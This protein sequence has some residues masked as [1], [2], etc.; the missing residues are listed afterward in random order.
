MQEEFDI[1]VIGSGLGGLECGVMLSREG[2]GVCIVEQAAVPGGCLQSFR[3]RGHSI[4]TGMHYVGSMQQGGIMRRYFDYF[5]IGDSL[6]IRPLDEAFDIVSPGGAGEFA[7]MHGYDEFRRHLTSLFPREAAGIARYCDKIREIGDSIGV[8]V[9]RSGRLSS[10]GVKYLGASAAEFIGECVADPLLRSVLA[11]TNPLYGGV[12]ERSP[13]YHHAM[14]NHSNIE[15]ACRFAGGTQHIAD[16]LAA[17]I[18]EHGGTILT[19]CRA[20]ALHTEGRRITGVELADGRI[21]RAK[22]VISAIHPAATFGLIGPTP[23]LRRAFRDRMAGM[24][25]TYGLFSVYLLLRPQSFPYINRNLYYYAEGGDVWDTLFDTEAMRPKMVLFSAQPPCA[26]PAWS[27]VVT[28]MAPIATDIWSA[29]SGSA[30]GRR[31]EAYTALKTAVAEHLTDFVCERLPGLRRRY[32]LRHGGH[33]PENGIVQRT[34]AVRRSGM[35]RGGDADGP[36]R[37]RHLVGMERIGAGPPSRSVYGPENGR[38]GASD[39]LRLRAA[40]RPAGGD[41]T[42]VRGHAPHLPALHRN[43]P[44]GCLRPAERLPQRH[45]DLH[46]RTD[47]IREPAAHGAEPDG[48]RR[49][50]GDALGGGDLRRAA[51]HGIS[52]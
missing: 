19:G 50:R 24:P 32:A 8:E 38:R 30:P 14:I 7:Y 25:G 17:R 37:H 51:G 52:G 2:M 11:G 22:S 26:D 33:A 36:D 27:E 4:D 12:R 13:L 3:R 43:P 45:G 1:I 47:E 6:E 9:H 34:A 29:W 46:S 39:G 41:R 28:L 23:V 16:A 5:G 18:R 48:S 21:L 10:G 49:D 44:R 15:G 42:D 35:E 40:A 31:P 20:S